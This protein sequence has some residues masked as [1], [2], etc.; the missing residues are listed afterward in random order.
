MMT[1]NIGANIRK[2]RRARGLTQSELAERI[3]LTQSAIGKYESGDRGKSYATGS[4]VENGRVTL[5][6]G[7]LVAICEALDCSL[8]DL[9]YGERNTDEYKRGFEDGYAMCKED[10]QNTFEDFLKNMTRSEK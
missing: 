10:M 2:Y 5:S 8:Y 7:T 4:R 3:G 1:D 9:V 6:I